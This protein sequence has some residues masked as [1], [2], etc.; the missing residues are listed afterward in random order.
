MASLPAKKLEGSKGIVPTLP[1]LGVRSPPLDF[2]RPDEQCEQAVRRRSCR[3]GTSHALQGSIRG[4]RGSGGD[5]ARQPPLSPP[6]SWTA[7]RQKDWEW[8]GCSWSTLAGHCSTARQGDRRRRRERES[9]GL[10]GEIS[11]PTRQ[12]SFDSGENDI[13]TYISPRQALHE[14]DSP[15]NRPGKTP[16]RDFGFSGG[17]PEL[18][19]RRIRRQIRLGSGWI[20]ICTIISAPQALPEADLCT[21]HPSKTPGRRFRF[22]DGLQEP[23]E[24][25]LEPNIVE[26]RRICNA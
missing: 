4:G 22:S 9:A 25:H 23:L 8:V 1:W 16:E 13:G 26:E 11:K 7:A 15:T 5:P 19:E 6:G 17:L 24:R 14:A 21:H 18:L 20:V 2:A 3:A 12:T 10:T